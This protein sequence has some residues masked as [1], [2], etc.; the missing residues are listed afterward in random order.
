MRILGMFMTAVLAISLVASCA[1]DNTPT[2]YPAE[3]TYSLVIR[4][5]DD[6]EL[7]DPYDVDYD[8]KDIT[9]YS[10][11]YILIFVKDSAGKFLE[12]SK[13]TTELEGDYDEVL[14]DS[15][16][17]EEGLLCVKIYPYNPGTYTYTFKCL[18]WGS[19]GKPVTVV[20]VP[21]TIIVHDDER[22]FE[23][24]EDYFADGYS[25]KMV[26]D[27]KWD[28][29]TEATKEITIPVDAY[30]DIYA[31]DPS[32]NLLTGQGHYFPFR[33]EEKDIISPCPSLASDGS[34][35]LSIRGVKTGT[36]KISYFFFEGYDVLLCRRTFT[37]N[38]V[39]KQ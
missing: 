33:Y 27:E 2:V 4:V 10:S 1:K 39:E 3:D 24:V 11:D 30:V 8:G 7:Y 6:D 13:Y 14:A 34:F 37:I 18:Y 15:Y 9:L 12:C 16:G 5:C 26:I 25:F 38:V 20:D 19:K 29:L 17:T 21:I 28:S 32:G 22:P 31:V 36:E 23:P 35:S